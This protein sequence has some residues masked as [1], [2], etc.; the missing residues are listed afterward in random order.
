MVL[1]TMYTPSGVVAAAVV[2]GAAALVFS[3]REVVIGDP[4]P[5]AGTPLPADPRTPQA[6]A[7]SQPPAAKLMTSSNLTPLRLRWRLSANAT[8]AKSEVVLWRTLTVAARS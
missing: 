5:D 6:P 7:A 2:T 3:G 8:A 4:T 1:S